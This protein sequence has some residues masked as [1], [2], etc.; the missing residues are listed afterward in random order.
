MVLEY[1]TNSVG[2]SLGGAS[3]AGTGSF[4]PPSTGFVENSTVPDTAANWYSFL[5]QP[6]VLI[7]GSHHFLDP[8]GYRAPMIFQLAEDFYGIPNLHNDLLE[9]YLAT[10]A[11][12]AAKGA[13]GRTFTLGTQYDFQVIYEHSAEAAYQ[14]NPSTVRYVK[15]PD[16]VSLGDPDKNGFYQCAVIA[17]PDL[18]FP[19]TDRLVAVPATRVIWGATLLNAAP[20]RGN[21][22]EFLQVLL[23]PAGRAAFNSSGPAPIVPALVSHRDFDRL[24]AQLRALVT[25]GEVFEGRGG[26]CQDHH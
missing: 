15:F 6:G 1:T 7:G 4:N 18:G 24:P 5:T 13:T 3:I 21:A 20:N 9:H 2:T 23:G 14:A 17:V 25:A 10:P 12:P 26:R 22:I 11:T 19:S 8:S 16:D